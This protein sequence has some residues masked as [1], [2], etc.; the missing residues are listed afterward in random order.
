[1]SLQHCAFVSLSLFFHCSLSLSLSL[2]VISL[3]LS[4]P[5][6][7]PCSYVLPFLRQMKLKR[8]NSTICHYI[9]IY[10]TLLLVDIKVKSPESRWD[11][12]VCVKSLGSP[13]GTWTPAESESQDQKAPESR[14]SR[15]CFLYVRPYSVIVLLLFAPLCTFAQLLPNPHASRCHRQFGAE[16]VREKE[17]NWP[18]KSMFMTHQFWEEKDVF[19]VEQKRQHFFYIYTHWHLVSPKHSC[20][21]RLLYTTRFPW[22][23]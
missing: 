22:A 11:C 17:N 8:W 18:P 1:M 7:L 6:F 12:S 20:F 23:S 4:V 19:S 15:Q 14:V 16:A 10:L 3:S 2:N 21:N 9:F 13:C 5:F